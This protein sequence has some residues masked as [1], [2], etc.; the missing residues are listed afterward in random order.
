MWKLEFWE[1]KTRVLG[2]PRA[3][4]FLQ[5]ENFQFWWKPPV[6]M[7][8]TKIRFS[9][10]KSKTRVLVENSSFEVLHQNSF[11]SI[12]RDIPLCKRKTRVSELKLPVLVEY[13]AKLQFWTS[14][15]RVLEHQTAKRISVFKSHILIYT[16]S[17]EL[18]IEPI[19]FKY[20]LSLF[21]NCLNKFAHEISEDWRVAIFEFILTYPQRQ[22]A[23]GD[24]WKLWR[25]S[26][27]NTNNKAS[28]N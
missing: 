27:S 1:S 16:S 18:L 4:T 24:S 13:S 6:L 28:T 12:N 23:M 2:N 17:F 10:Q 26:S 22:K 9:Y 3:S 15:T 20:F 5:F 11:W 7:F 21:L 19:W 8:W 25:N 14:K